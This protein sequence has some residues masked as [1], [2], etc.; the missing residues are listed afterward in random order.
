M[1][2][3]SFNVSISWDGLLVVYIEGLQHVRVLRLDVVS[4]EVKVVFIGMKFGGLRHRYRVAETL[5]VSLKRMPDILNFRRGRKEGG[6]RDNQCDGEEL[7][8][9]MSNHGECRCSVFFDNFEGTF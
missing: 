7:D 4:L 6:M 1:A 8:K 5:S 2:R 9:R 3:H